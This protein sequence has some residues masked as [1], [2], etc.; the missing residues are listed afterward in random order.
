MCVSLTYH[1]IKDSARKIPSW[2]KLQRNYENQ[3]EKIKSNKYAV[4][5]DKDKFS[6]K[7][8]DLWIVYIAY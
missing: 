2:Y 7:W 3:Y 6:H 1:C 8:K 4:T 5:C